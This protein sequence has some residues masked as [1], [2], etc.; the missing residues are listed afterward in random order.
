MANNAVNRVGQINAAGA[1][2]AIFL[3]VFSGEVITHFEEVNKC[4]NAHMVRN[5]SSGKSAQFPVMGVAAAEYHTP[6]AQLLGADN[7]RHAER[8]INIDSLLVTH[9]SLAN[10]DEAMNHYDV[11]GEY[12]RKMAEALSVKADEQLLRLAYLAAREGATI[13]GLNGGTAITDA[14]AD[15]NGA[16]LASTA[17]QIAQTFDEK[18]VPETERKLWVAPAQYY[19]LVQETGLV[20]TD[21]SS[22]NG[23]YAKGQIKVVGG[24]EIVKTNHLPSGVVSADSGENNTYNGTFTNSVCVATHRSA[25]GTV[26]LLDLAMEKEYQISRQSTLMVAKYAMGHGIL[27]PEAAVEVKTA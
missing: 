9:E 13:T 7:M 16:S 4:I 22:A 12:A 25:I 5:I 8:T 10:I 19:L 27:R 3:K 15:T 26:K 1:T 18:N 11:R 23:D 2:D 21:F 14:D 6:G 17:Y 24:L 20:D